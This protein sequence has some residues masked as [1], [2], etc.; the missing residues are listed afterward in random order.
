MGENKK[1]MKAHTFSKR[2]HG[3]SVGMQIDWI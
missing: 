1:E 3:I 2:N